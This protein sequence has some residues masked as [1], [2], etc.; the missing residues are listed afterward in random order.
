MT[1]RMQTCPH[2]GM[3]SKELEQEPTGQ[4]SSHEHDAS[5]MILDPIYWSKVVETELVL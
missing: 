2:M 4:Y 1:H 5:I 3:R